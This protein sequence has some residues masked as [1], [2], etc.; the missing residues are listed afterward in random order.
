[1]SQKDST[2]SVS[3]L[4][5]ERL[6]SLDDLPHFPDALAKLEKSLASGAMPDL[7]EITQMII[8]DPR[9]TTGLIGVANTAKYSTGNKISDLA[10]A[11]SRIGVKDVRLMAHAINYKSSFKS[12]PPFSEKQF[13]KHALLCAFIA[14]D[15][16]KSVHLNPGEAFL[17]G[18]MKDLGIYLLSIESRERYQKVIDLSLAEMDRI[19][20][21]EAEIFSTNHSVMSAR[22]L[23]QWKFSNDIVMGVASHHAP[24]KSNPAFQAYAYLVFLAEYGALS[25]GVGNG[26][27]SQVVAE[28]DDVG[29]ERLFA[30]LEYFG[31]AP[32]TY[33]DLVEEALITFE[34]LSMV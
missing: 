9:L 34:E 24:E 31:L 6:K 18:L 23:K 30:A 33:D 2:P 22:L 7:N 28:I 29:N 11:V 1:M 21:A 25:S 10:E 12:K 14:Q 13:L 8:Q 5:L 19:Q 15:I 27:V 4:V 32:S 17:A 16:A 3:N 20:S 26:V